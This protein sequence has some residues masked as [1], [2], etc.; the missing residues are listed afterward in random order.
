MGAG[1]PRRRLWCRWC[2]APPYDLEIEPRSDGALATNRVLVED[3]GIRWGVAA[4]GHVEGDEL[5]LAVLMRHGVGREQHGA[6]VGTEAA[7]RGMP[8]HEYQNRR[9]A[10]GAIVWPNCCLM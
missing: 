9:V 2:I 8:C 6:V 3:L 5:H 10:P 4:L 1:L 7:A